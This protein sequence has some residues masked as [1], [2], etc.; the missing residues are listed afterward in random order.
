MKQIIAT[1]VLLGLSLVSVHAEDIDIFT[2]GAGQEGNPNILIIVDSSS[3]W[4]ETFADGSKKFDAEVAAIDAVM[5]KLGTYVNGDSSKGKYGEKLNIGLMMFAESGDNGAYVRYAIRTMN[6]NNRAAFKGLVDNWV[7]NGSGTDNSGS[8]QP[9]GKV[10]FEAFKYFGGHTSP[11]HSNDNTAGSPADNQHFGPIAF[12]GGKSNDAGSYRRDYRTNNSAGN[13]AA[14]NYYADQAAYDAAGTAAFADEASNT[15]QSP[16]GD[17]CAKN[18]IIFISNGSI[19]VGGDAGSPDAPT[20]LGNI[21]GLTSN[22]KNPLTGAVISANTADEWARYLYQTDVSPLAGQQKVMTYTLAAYDATKETNGGTPDQIALAKSMALQGGGKY[23]KATSSAEAVNALLTILD[24][25]QSVNSTFVTASLPVNTNAQGE[26]TN[27]VFIGMFRPETNATPRWW[28]NLKQY[29]LAIDST[30]GSVAL[31]DAQSPPVPV[32]KSGSGFV[33]PTAQSFWSTKGDTSWNTG[34]WVNDPK[35]NGGAFDLPDGEIVE[36]GGAAELLRVDYKT[37]QTSRKVLTCPT[38]GCVN[39]STLIDFTSTNLSSVSSSFG[40]PGTGG[41]T[42]ADFIDWIR[43]KDNKVISDEKGPGSPTT[44]RPS[45]HGDVVHSRPVAIDF[46]GDTGVVVFY[47][48]ND[49]MLRA[50]TGKQNGGGHELWS[51]I[52]PEFYGKFLRLYNNSPVLKMPDTTAPGAAPKD[53]FWDGPITAYQDKAS[54]KT[55]VYVG[56]RRGGNFMYA[57]DVSDL[58]NPK[59]L[60]KIDPSN[61]DFAKLGQTWSSPS[62]LPI[63]GYTGPVLVF[64]GGYAGGYG[65]AP[66]YASQCED[67][68]PAG[69]T[70]CDYAYGVYLVDAKLGTRIK[71]IYQNTDASLSMSKSVPADIYPMDSDFNGKVDRLYVGDLGGNIWRIDLGTPASGTTPKHEL[72]KLASLGSDKKLFFRPSILQQNSYTL[73]S[74]GTGDREKPLA[75]DTTDWF[76]AVKDTATGVFPSSIATQGLDDLQCIANGSLACSGAVA[77]THGWKLPLETGE[78]VINAP[79]VVF[80]TMNFSTNKPK[81]THDPGI[82]S[83]LGLS[84]AYSVIASDSVA[85]SNYTVLPPDV[86]FAP[87]AFVGIVDIN[88]TKVPVCIGCPPPPCTGADCATPCTGPTCVSTKAINVPAVRSKKFWYK[89]GADQ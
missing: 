18:F 62:V 17:G 22:I 3:N 79:R 24:E 80:G 40:L 16:I 29:Q 89:K 46:G 49:G 12:A 85:S 36:K 70:G 1:L 51:F 6:D 52:P 55:Y 8:N 57:L 63:E 74:I 66:G 21:G 58:D 32:S 82:C 60:W 4:G 43:G 72:Y 56:A 71:F 13:R 50:V 84:R 68:S 64:G 81:A 83:D 20:L 67:A 37:S 47:G 76:V 30:T 44:V 31:V 23:F 2:G 34:F 53:Y 69:T 11:A 14:R 35:G 39:G 26:F 65:S 27:Q 33:T 54:G 15:Y 88:G 25:I 48:G 38:A 7:M 77:N 5:V 86:A 61:T 19:S 10:M 41:P 28:G 87:T 9:Y 75:T 59:A 42:F 45:I 78:K 73:V